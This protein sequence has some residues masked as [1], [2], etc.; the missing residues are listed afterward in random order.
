MLA[1]PRSLRAALSLARTF[2]S[3]RRAMSACA[4]WLARS[5]G[6][7]DQI[8]W[9]LIPRARSTSSR[10][11]LTLG[12]VES[13]IEALMRGVSVSFSVQ[14]PV[15]RG[16]GEPL[17]L[18]NRAWSQLVAPPRLSPQIRPP[19]AMSSRASRRRNCTSERA[20]RSPPSCCNDD[21]AFDASTH[22]RRAAAHN[23]SRSGWCRRSRN[24][25]CARSKSTAHAE[26]VCHDARVPSRRLVNDVPC[27]NKWRRKVV[28]GLLSTACPFER[29]V[30][31]GSLAHAAPAAQMGPA[32]GSSVGW[33]SD[34]REFA[35]QNCL[36]HPHTQ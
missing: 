7:S 4:A 17:D 28:T 23:C 25:R 29:A 13:R 16:A 11:V 1:P 20:P 30:A 24:S 15:S 12:R 8:S 36:V 32:E 33:Y 31:P 22:H 2:S 26:A 6:Q 3:C 14:R 10:R 34:C 35:S 9:L 27:G 19:S 21:G 18:F 5:T